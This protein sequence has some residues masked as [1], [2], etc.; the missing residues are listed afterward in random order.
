MHSAVVQCGGILEIV[1]LIRLFIEI[2][3]TVCNVANVGRP[4]LVDELEEKDRLA[5]K[6]VCG[7]LRERELNW[8]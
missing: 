5:S 6:Q 7:R 3:T 1:E 4:K 2:Q 8:M